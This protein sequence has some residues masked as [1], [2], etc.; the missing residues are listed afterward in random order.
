MNNNTIESL[1]VKA[2]KESI[3]STSR[4]E[5]Y[6]QE[7]DKEPLWDGYVFIYNSDNHSNDNLKGKVATQ[8]KGKA[9][10]N[11]SKKEISYQVEIHELQTYQRDGGIIYFVV[12]LDDNTKNKKIY[13]ETLLPVK[14]GLYLDKIKKDN[15]K[16]V[17]I[18][19][20]EFPSKNIA[21]ESIFLNFEDDSKKQTSFVSQG[22]L[23]LEQLLKNSPQ[24]YSLSIQ[25]YSSDHN[26]NQY[27]HLLDNEFYVYVTPKN[28]NLFIPTKTTSTQLEI[29]DII[30]DQISVNSFIYYTKFE[31]IQSSKSIIIKIGNS[32][33]LIFPRNQNDTETQVKI[34]MTSSLKQII[35]DLNFIINAIENQ[36]FYIGNMELK[37][38]ITDKILN[39]LDINRQKEKLLFYQKI[40]MVLNILN[41]NDDLDLKLLVDSQIRDLKILI[42]VFIEKEN[43]SNI[44][45]KHS[46]A[47]I[48]LKIA[49]LTLKLLII[50]NNKE[51][52]SYTIED[53]FNSSSYLSIS[54]K[55]GKKYIV[56]P[57]SALTK[58]DYTTISN[59]DHDNILISYQKLIEIND[60]IYEFANFDMLNM[61][62]AYDEKPDPRL[63]N[64]IKKISDWLYSNPNENV[65]REITLLNHFQIIKRERELTEEE[66]SELL[67]FIED[68]SQPDDIKL[69]SHLLL[70]NQVRAKHYFKKLDKATQENFKTYPI[71]LFGKNI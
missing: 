47:V 11:F 40:G 41:I 6:I 56:P 38:P 45:T 52:P 18:K 48:N 34:A 39:K 67:D 28:T 9:N 49:N 35:V 21:K 68:A 16:K 30:E 29:C 71:Y 63:F 44:N 57:F 65:S 60:R 64:T 55:D 69:A 37:L 59:I 66:K 53:F 2:V 3:L 17:S 33:T 22:F 19:L 32:T 54:D 14:I 5:S 70:G 50:K 26:Q 51:K 23:S 58:N 15:Q 7:K 1:A 61:L 31:R 46:I 25:G 20:T 4:L 8:V 24:E 43:V 13:Y 42:K 12:Y 36:S 62:L 10:K 27:S